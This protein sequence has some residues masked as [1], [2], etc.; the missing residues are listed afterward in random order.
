MAKQKID[1]KTVGD[2]QIRLATAK[3]EIRTG[4]ATDAMQRAKDVAVDLELDQ[5]E[6][7]A[8]AV[9][10]LFVQQERDELLGMVD[11]E[12][13]NIN[14]AS[15]AS[16]ANDFVRKVS[17][18]VDGLSPAIPSS[19]SS[20]PSVLRSDIG[21]EPASLQSGRTANATPIFRCENL[22]KL[23]SG[24]PA[25]PPVTLEIHPG[26]IVAVLG[27]NGTGK[28]TLLRMIARNLSHSD[29]RPEWDDLGH[30]DRHAANMIA[31]V[32]QSPSPW[33]GTLREHLELTAAL[34][35]HTGYSANDRLVERALIDLSI[36]H[37]ADRRCVQ[38]SAGYRMRAAIAAA[39]MI[40]PLLIILDEPLGPLDDPYGQHDLLAWMRRAVSRELRRSVVF[41]SLHVRQAERIADTRVWLNES[42]TRNAGGLD[43]HHGQ[44][45]SARLGGRV[46]AIVEQCRG[47]TSARHEVH[48]FDVWVERL[49]DFLSV[50]GAMTLGDDALV[51]KF[52]RFEHIVRIWTAPSKEARVRVIEQASLFGCREFQDYTGVIP[53][54]AAIAKDV[55]E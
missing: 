24:V 40:N 1:A 4:Q 14:R 45:D 33:E 32:A 29:G 27:L 11:Y 20:S 23:F 17:K 6:D 51:R 26:E 37:L 13:L 12:Q 22:I 50:L 3:A 15:R 47:S 2:M 46:P 34:C 42:I 19:V 48:I 38:L 55:H 35:G 41:S 39:M 25:T 44:I 10:S 5:L 7:D 30:D 9:I 28:S 18:E 43:E 49:D 31:Y 53:G 8:N 16:K 21:L 54:Q 36:G 52:H